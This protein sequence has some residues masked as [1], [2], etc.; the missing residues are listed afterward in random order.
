MSMLKHSCA[1]V[2]LGWL[3]ACSS[4]NPYDKNRELLESSSASLAASNYAASAQAAERLYAGRA[5]EADQF[6][7]QRFY[8]LY[9]AAGAHVRAAI[10]KPFL[11]VDSGAG[12][13]SAQNG[14]VAH[15][16]AASY[17][18]G[19]ARDLSASAEKEK[20]VVEEVHLLPADMEALTVRNA[21]EKL[22]LFR[23]VAL[24]RL[25]FSATYQS[26]LERWAALQKIEGC[27]ETIG[28]V[29]LEKELVPWVFYT[30]FRFMK[31]RNDADA[32]YIFGAKAR[33]AAKDTEGAIPAERTA[34]IVAWVKEK[35]A[36]VE[37]ICQKCRKPFL[38]DML[39]CGD[40]GTP[41]TQFFSVAKAAK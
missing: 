37:F 5:E 13:G 35:A 31:D 36:S 12:I 25:G 41:I 20:P 40:D 18:V 24:S 32:A 30:L 2:V 26:E 23:L 34:E 22:E 11:G 14:D 8:A 17:Y 33:V 3:A 1:F 6:E 28:R 19:L 39:R 4:I 27:E 38:P 15:L 9:L 29:A 21:Q 10:H 16:V 7:L